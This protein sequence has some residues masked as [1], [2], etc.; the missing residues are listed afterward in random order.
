MD[1]K[2]FKSFLNILKQNITLNKNMIDKALYE[3]YSK[4]MPINFEKIYSYIERYEKG[5]EFFN[6]GKNISVVYNGLPEVTIELVLDAMIHNNRVTFFITNHKELNSVLIDCIVNSIVDTRLSNKW[7]DFDVDYNEIYLKDN[8]NKFENIIFIGDYLEYKRLESLIGRSM[9][10]YN[11]GNIKIYIDMNEYMDEYRKIS[12]YCFKN[13]ISLETFDDIDDFI[14]SVRKEDNAMIYADFNAINQI[15]R[16]GNA[17]EIRFNDF[18]YDD[19]KFELKR[20]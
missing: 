17:D 1:N 2:E 8:A 6:E 3:D 4:K 11:Y 16:L 20:N 13:S 12:D 18:P 5:T 19:Y 9:E 14:S 10:Y 15:N 7:I